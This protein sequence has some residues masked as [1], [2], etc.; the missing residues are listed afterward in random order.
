[1]RKNIT[2]G[3]FYDIP[4]IS[5]QYLSINKMRHII[6]SATIQSDHT[7]LLVIMNMHHEQKNN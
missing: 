4:E 2:N 1:M 7:I 3:L 5:V 6:E